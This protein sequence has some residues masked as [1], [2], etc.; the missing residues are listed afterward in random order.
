MYSEEY[1]KYDPWGRLVGEACSDDP[2]HYQACDKKEIG[3]KITN[4][5]LLCEHYMCDM[6]DN[7]LRTSPKLVQTVS[8]YICDVTCTNTDLNKQDCSEE[9]VTLPTG[10]KVRSSEICDGKCKHGQHGLCEDES[11]CN[12]YMYGLYCTHRFNKKLWYVQPREICDRHSLCKDRE[13]E[14]NCTVSEDTESSCKHFRIGKLV[15]IHNYTRCTE[16]DISKYFSSKPQ[17]YCRLSDIVKQQ[18]NCSDP[19]RVALTC[20]IN[21]FMSTVSKY[22]IC[23]D[24]TIS[25][26]D[27]K[28]ESKCL[29]TRSCRIHRHFMCDNIDDCV[30]M[31]D[32]RDPICKSV[33]EATCKRRAG[34]GSELPIPIAWL[35][36][37]VRDCKNGEDETDD[38]ST[39]GV[40]RRL[41]YVSSKEVEC[42]NVFICRTG[43]PGYV[44]LEKLCDGLETCGNENKICSVSNRLQSLA[45]SV[46]TTKKG[47]TKRLS[48]CLSGLANLQLLA[49]RCVTEKHLYPDENIFGV[50][51]KTSV[52]LPNTTQ[53]CDHMYGEQ[54]LYTSCTGRCISATCPLRNI[55]RYEVCPDQYPDRIGTI[56]NNEYLIFVT[57][58]QNSVYSNRYFVC[59]DKIKCIEYSKVCDLIN[60]CD[61]KSDEDNCLNHFK[62]TPTGK[63]IPKTK[64]C[65]GHFDCFD[66]SDEC[67]EQCSKEILEELWLMGLSWLIGFL[68]VVANLVIIVKC[69]I[70]FRRCKTTV[71]LIN[72]CLILVIALGDFLVGCYLFIIATYDGIVFK[73]SYCHQQ[74]TWITSLECS[75]IGVIS[76]I[77]SQ[78]SLFAMTGLSIVRM[79]GI[80]NSMRIPGEVTAMKFVKIVSPMI[81]L[82][83]ISAAIAVIPIM[84][85]FEDFFVNGVK[86]SDEIK[87][88][89]GT[90]NK[91]TVFE[92]I[93]GYYGRTEDATLNWRML[94][95]MVKK[96]FSRDLD[97]KDLTE[98]VDK[99]KFYGNDG[100]CLFKYF[101]QNDDPQ[102]LFVWSILTINFV[103]F[104]FISLSYLLIGIL[105]RKSSEGLASSQN[106]QIEKRNR[107]MN[108]RIA[109]II[110]T[111]F[112]CWIPFI[113]ICILHSL[114]V[115]NATS[116][117]SIFSMVILPI[118]SVINPLLYDDAVTKVFR[119]P[120]QALVACVY[121][122][123]IFQRVHDL[124]IVTKDTTM[125]L[126]EHST[127]HLSNPA[128]TE[129]ERQAS[130]L[131]QTYA[132]EYAVEVALKE[133]QK[134]ATGEAQ[135]K[136][137]ELKEPSGP[138]PQETSGIEPQEASGL[139][140]Q[141]AS[142]LEPQE[143]SGPEP[144]E[145]S[146]L[147][148][149]EASGLEPQEASGPEPQEASEL[150]PQEASGLEPQETSGPEPQEA[151]GLE[152][153]ETSG[154]EMREASGIES[155]ETSE[156]EPQEASERHT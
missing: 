138:E 152:P 139:E 49:K 31:A 133:T 100:V 145:A 105:S 53:A 57:K 74:I 76:T 87:I 126:P 28:I 55:P 61:D 150:E 137:V 32:E 146:G 116:W 155:Q 88:F 151:S 134:Y 15:P 80:W 93:Q 71:A 140:P 7:D 115:L 64:K 54:Y 50:T 2:H 70:V 91:A 60:D 112:L 11:T 19:S 83:L 107:R 35:R 153:Q 81:F 156:F 18:T 135:N 66:F 131:T 29:T 39:C 84:E 127:R 128:P 89:V 5:E 144:Q 92:V 96:M 79:H 23:F 13:D 25:A 38:W 94:I 4:N 147:E 30:D 103:C 20:E 78:I 22:I 69:I 82:V 73:K 113:I 121:N 65:D 136:I 72:R 143:T 149:Q 111:D 44:E 119:A 132:R 97:Y 43:D 129:R 42:R 16:I 62:C 51:T 68:A 106:K 34:L 67:N 14:E 114:E 77:G 33:T 148:P 45:T 47:F 110:A 99:V 3:G 26:C 101:V 36:D 40:G 85:S 8:G 56:V 27:D 52:I 124:G 118:N 58:S 98:R 75:I 104:V 90:S 154:P 41:R 37:G 142:G 109:V 21:G 86:F 63:L 12:G 48:Y 120:I 122:S 6:G 123:G 108:R 102:R 1:Y 46:L 117:Y 95:Q 141:E 125:V 59:D 24:D 130:G 9:Q 10:T 17:Q